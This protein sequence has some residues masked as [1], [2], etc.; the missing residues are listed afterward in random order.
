MNFIP[1]KTTKETAVKINAAIM[2][3]KCTLLICEGA[4]I[5]RKALAAGTVAVTIKIHDATNNAQPAKKPHVGPKIFPTQAYD[6]PA[7]GISLFKLMNASVIPNMIIPQYST[8]AGDRRPTA[9]MIVEAVTSILYAGAVPAIPIV[10][11]SNRPSEDPFSE[12][13]SFIRIL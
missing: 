13:V 7:L 11:D 1:F 12:A 2:V 9:A 10:I 5:R 4:K 3:I 8:L 6:A